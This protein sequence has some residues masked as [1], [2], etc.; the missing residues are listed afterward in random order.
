MRIALSS[1]EHSM[2]LERHSARLVALGNSEYLTRLAID[3][4][5]WGILAVRVDIGGV[6]SELEDELALPSQSLVLEGLLKLEPVEAGYEITLLEAF[7]EQVAVKI[8]SKIA[9]RI[10]PLCRQL[11]LVL[12]NLDCDVLE[13]T[14]SV[15]QVPM[16]A[17]GEVFL[18][19]GEEL[20]EGEL[21]EL[22]AFLEAGSAPP[23]GAPDAP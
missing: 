11:S 10:V 1:P 23:I 7:Q 3:F 18:L 9:G 13:E 4:H 8:E 21:E 17:P 6:E 20:T 19:P 2:T 22:N 15:V 12:V 5:G 16:P 14:L